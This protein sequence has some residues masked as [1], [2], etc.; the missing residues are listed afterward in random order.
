MVQYPE[1]RSGGA[2]SPTLHEGTKEGAVTGAH[3]EKAAEQGRLCGFRLC[4]VSPRGHRAEHTPTPLSS[5]PSLCMSPGANPT[6]SGE[7]R[8]PCCVPHGSACPAQSRGKGGNC[9]EQWR[10]ALQPD[11]HF[12]KEAYNTVSELREVL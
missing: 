7:Q 12:V 4:A 10:E 5:S 1:A 11:F 2:L 6:H 9:L 3:R 8:R